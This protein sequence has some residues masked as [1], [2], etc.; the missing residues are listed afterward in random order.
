[1]CFLLLMTVAVPGVKDK[2]NKKNKMI[3]TQLEQRIHAV[4]ENI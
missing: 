1:M 4:V 3:K 2:K